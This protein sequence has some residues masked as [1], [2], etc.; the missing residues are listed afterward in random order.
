MIAVDYSYFKS[1]LKS[2]F[3]R[4][5]DDSETVIVARKDNQNVDIMTEDGYNNLLENLYIRSSKANYDHLLH[6]MAQAEASLLHR[7]P[8]SEV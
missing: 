1:H 8:M 3:D 7:K 5:H 6:S 2:V 4:C